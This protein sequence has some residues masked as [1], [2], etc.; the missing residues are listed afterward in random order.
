MFKGHPHLTEIHPTLFLDVHQLN[1]KNPRKHDI[2]SHPFP[3]LREIEP[4][5]C[6]N[7][8]AATAQCMKNDSAKFAF[9][10]ASGATTFE[11]RAHFRARVQCEPGSRPEA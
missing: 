1:R 4:Q 3:A 5:A 8:A 11:P 10:L 9:Q 2:Q 6:H 7:A